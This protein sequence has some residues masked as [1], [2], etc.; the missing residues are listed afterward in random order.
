VLDD[1]EELEY[2]WRIHTGCQTLNQTLSLALSILHNDIRLAGRCIELG[3][4]L[5][6][7]AFPFW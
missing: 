3:E 7:S 2:C 5:S 4:C 1:V 6:F